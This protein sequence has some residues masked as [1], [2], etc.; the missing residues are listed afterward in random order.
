M[1]LIS[2]LFDL[3]GSATGRV[4]GHDNLIID[5]LEMVTMVLNEVLTLSVPRTKL[6]PTWYEYLVCGVSS[7]RP[8]FHVLQKKRRMASDVKGQLEILSARHKTLP[9]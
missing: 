8:F 2:P 1:M 7:G 9:Q 5:E 3:L 6:V 4:Y